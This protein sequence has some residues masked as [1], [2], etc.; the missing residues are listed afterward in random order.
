[1]NTII[2]ERYNSIA[3]FRKA[4]ERKKIGKIYD[5]NNKEIFNNDFAERTHKK[6]QMNF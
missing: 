2:N 5:E 3:E 6:K 4:L 1:M